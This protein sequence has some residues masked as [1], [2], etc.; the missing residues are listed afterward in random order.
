[1]GEIRH[2]LYASRAYL[3][4]QGRGRP[5]AAL[6]WVAPDE[7]LAH[8]EQSKWLA[9]HVAPERVAMTV[10]SLVVKTGPQG[11]EY[12]RNAPAGVI[13]IKYFCS[14]NSFKM[15]M[16]SRETLGVSSPCNP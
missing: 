1:M 14:P 11:T 8:L 6:D 15:V 3:K 16:S 10:D 13:E 9:R 4:S 7:S 2:G 12:G 5:L